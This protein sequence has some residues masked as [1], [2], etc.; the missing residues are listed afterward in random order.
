MRNQWT[1]YGIVGGIVSYV[2]A[3]AIYGYNPAEPIV[4]LIAALPLLMLLAIPI[5]LIL[6][7]LIPTRR[8]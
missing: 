1:G 5:C 7:L 6:V 8:L 2:F 4:R 3:A